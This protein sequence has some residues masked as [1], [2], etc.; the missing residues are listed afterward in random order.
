MSCT[1]DGTGVVAHAAG[2]YHFWNRWLIANWVPKQDP[3]L[4]VEL[5][6]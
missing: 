4:G 2:R 3:D 5:A 1:A 6:H